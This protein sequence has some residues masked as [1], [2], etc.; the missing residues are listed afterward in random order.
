MTTLER[1]SR[2][3]EN[4]RKSPTGMQIDLLNDVSILRHVES[5]VV[6]LA[7]KT[8]AVSRV[9][10]NT[11]IITLGERIHRLISDALEDGQLDNAPITIAEL[12]I[13]EASF[14]Q[15]FRGMMHKRID[16]PEILKD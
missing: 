13:I 11:S 10:S 4:T 7:D 3:I 12:T 8:E 9:L 14:I 2:I 16:Y 1:Y 5:A 6:F 15:Y